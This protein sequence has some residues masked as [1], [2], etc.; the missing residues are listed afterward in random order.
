MAV[1]NAC[2]YCE[3]FCAVFPAMERR[4][5]F[6]EADI[7]YLA[8]LCHNCAECYYACQYAPPHEFAVNVPKIFAEIRRRSYEAYAWPGF[9][10]VSG[11][12]AVGV[13]IA[14]A[15]LL[16]GARSATG[17]DF[18]GVI[19]HEAMVTAFG[20][21]AVFVIVAQVAGFLRFWRESGESL[22]DFFRVSFLLKGLGDA[23]SLKNL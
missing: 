5:T 6:N 21:L 11:W 3:G 1:C 7:H 4:L 17:A 8:N 20:L 19:S 13:G 15:T 14:V 2:R 16:G 9:V 12:W 22:T 18:Y 10:K 23:L